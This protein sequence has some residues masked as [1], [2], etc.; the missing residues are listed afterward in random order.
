L[1]ILHLSVL[2]GIMYTVIIEARG[3]LYALRKR[4]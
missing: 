1:K 4:D 3:G 2:H